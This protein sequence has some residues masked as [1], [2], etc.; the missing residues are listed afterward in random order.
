MKIKRDFQFG[1]GG[2]SILMIFV[3]LCLTTFGI[4]S[5][6]T[7]NADY[8]ISNKNAETVQN[9]YKAYAFSQAKLQQIDSALLDARK[10]AE[11]AVNENSCEKLKNKS[12]YLSKAALDTIYTS[13]ITAEQK[14]DAFYRVFAQALVS[15]NAG[16]TF[17]EAQTGDGLNC[18]FTSEA[19]QNRQILVNLTLNPY[20]STE[21]Y[22]IT[23]EKLIN[24]SEP[25]PE[26]EEKLQLWQ[27]N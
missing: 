25:Q 2:S 11:Q 3:I 24:V 17:E 23:G 16:V 12:I 4:L 1:V 18:S 22:R 15:R 19:D 13:G 26:E 8:K 20:H 7:A 9:Y 10:D 21:P 6:V 5:F 14:Y 27:G